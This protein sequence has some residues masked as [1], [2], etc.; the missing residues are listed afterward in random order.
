MT[1]L[2]ESS[3]EQ[4]VTGNMWVTA[5]V[6]VKLPEYPTPSS[7]RLATSAILLMVIPALHSELER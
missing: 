1:Q 2:S 5:G 7:I 4:Q 3:E 6:E